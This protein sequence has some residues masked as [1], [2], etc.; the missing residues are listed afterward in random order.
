MWHPWSLS[1]RVAYLAIVP[2]VPYSILSLIFIACCIVGSH[3]CPRPSY[4][5]LTTALPSSQGYITG[6][7]LYLYLTD[8]FGFGLVSLS[9][10]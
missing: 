10:R 5:P 6:A 7:S 8:R 4:V 1:R 2:Q 9:T 3:S